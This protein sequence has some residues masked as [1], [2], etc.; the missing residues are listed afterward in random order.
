MALFA[1]LPNWASILITVTAAVIAVGLVSWGTYTLVKPSPSNLPEGEEQ[2][3][4]EKSPAKEDQFKD[5]KTYTNTTYGFETKYPTDWSVNL[6]SDK[7]INL[8]P[9]DKNPLKGIKIFIDDNPQQLSLREFYNGKHGYADLFND[10]AGGYTSLDLDGK[11]A[12]R[13]KDVLGLVTIDVVVIPLNKI[14]IRIEEGIDNREI[15]NQI[16]STFK[17]IK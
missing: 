17:F 10:A 3:A 8:L 12:T 15:F 7:I 13:F 2:P 14:N 4:G 1:K 16:L 11:S 6:I 5:W 9:A